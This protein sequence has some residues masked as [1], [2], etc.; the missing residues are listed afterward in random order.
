MIS[1]VM[2]CRHGHQLCVWWSQ[3]YLLETGI[4]N[5][6]TNIQTFPF[7]TWWPANNTV[8][9][10]ER[11]TNNVITN[12][13]GEF[14]S[15]FHIRDTV[16]HAL[17]CTGSPKEISHIAHSWIMESLLTLK[18]VVPQ[19][20]HVCKICSYLWVKSQIKHAHQNQTQFPDVLAVRWQDYCLFLR[21]RIN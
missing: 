9:V 16:F 7:Q 6:E 17:Y 2:Y 1:V 4:R 13:V 8:I 11:F 14:F 5:V 10:I 18:D 3:Y 20:T 12:T 19:N 15:H 21:Y